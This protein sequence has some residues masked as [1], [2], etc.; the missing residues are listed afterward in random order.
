MISNHPHFPDAKAIWS[1]IAFTRF[2]DLARYFTQWSGSIEQLSCG[3]FR[4]TIR[5]VKG[6]TVRARYVTADQAVALRGAEPPSQVSICPVLPETAGCFWQGRSVAAGQVVVRTGKVA[7]DHRTSRRFGNLCIS[8]HA[9]EFHR[10]AQIL[11]GASDPPPDWATMAPAPATFARLVTRAKALVHARYPHDVSDDGDVHRLEQ[12]CLAAV[13]EVMCPTA[14]TAGR[15]LSL[16]A[17]EALVRRAVDFLRA[18]LRE[19]I[20]EIDLCRE[21]GV[22]GRT[23]R[24]AF[25]ERFGLGPITYFQSIRLH[26]ARSAL[27]STDPIVRGIAAVAR[28]FG[29]T[30]P[31][32]FAGYYRRQFGEAPSATASTARVSLAS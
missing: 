9:D 28:E 1:D 3:R 24:L 7:V 17:R 8:V 11:A 10:T 29:F 16:P 25:R 21:L 4:G 23:L 19:P 6:R 26:A 15:L 20:G 2:E 12:S 32:K 27:Q 31:G 13:V 14:D 22:S 5:V 30:H 18:R